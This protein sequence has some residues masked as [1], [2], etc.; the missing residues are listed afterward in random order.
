M[1]LK[2]SKFHLLPLIRHEM[3]LVD[4]T[5]CLWIE[6][7]ASM[8]SD[9]SQIYWVSSIGKYRAR[10]KLRF[11]KIL[12]KQKWHQPGSMNLNPLEDRFIQGEASQI[13]PFPEQADCG[14][15]Q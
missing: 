2:P 4:K 12:Q 9:M 11:W 15:H 10:P 7:L 1:A 14:L 8:L 3:S 13:K 5:A 6:S